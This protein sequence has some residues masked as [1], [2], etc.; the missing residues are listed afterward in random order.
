MFMRQGSFGNARD[1]FEQAIGLCPSLRQM[2]ICQH[3]EF[4]RKREGKPLLGSQ[5]PPAS[6]Q[7]ISA[8]YLRTY[9][10]TQSNEESDSCDA[11]TAVRF[12]PRVEA[13]ME[14]GAVEQKSA[15]VNQ[16]FTQFQHAIENR[17]QLYA[18]S[19]D[20]FNG[21]QYTTSTWCAPQVLQRPDP[22]GSTYASSSNISPF[23]DVRQVL[24]TLDELPAVCEGYSNPV[25][26]L[27]KLHQQPHQ[28]LSF[29]SPSY[30]DRDPTDR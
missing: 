26:L 20:E 30:G 27:S 28:G 2:S 7:D 29:K 16:V 14:I 17:D 21:T 12:K 9:T 23:D 24:S 25:H 3:L 15:V 8:R 22:V 19:F 6:R 13:E 10:S 18:S 11:V 5:P 1:A 4:C